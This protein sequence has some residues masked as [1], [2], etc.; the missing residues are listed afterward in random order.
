MSAEGLSVSWWLEEEL[1]TLLVAPKCLV[2]KQTAPP[3]ICQPS[4]R[5]SG[6]QGDGLPP[7]E[8]R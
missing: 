5:R 6:A 2:N 8:R 4:G 1:P 7:F 3:V